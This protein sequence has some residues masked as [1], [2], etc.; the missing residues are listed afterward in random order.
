MLNYI[1]ILQIV[2]VTIVQ[3]AFCYFILLSWMILHV[4]TDT[5]FHTNRGLKVSDC[6]TSGSFPLSESGLTQAQYTPNISDLTL[7]F[8]NA[9]GSVFWLV[10]GFFLGG[11]QEVLIPA[12]LSTRPLK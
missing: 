4:N 2:F 7:H 5:W 6:G 8:H 1:K 11:G 3:F 12:Y 10:L 9:E